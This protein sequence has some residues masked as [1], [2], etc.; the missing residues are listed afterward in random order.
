MR[1]A[2]TCLAVCRILRALRT[3]TLRSCH[4]EASETLE[5][6]QQIEGLSVTISRPYVPVAPRPDFQDGNY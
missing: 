4:C 1:S 2:F 3:L 6:L 5:A